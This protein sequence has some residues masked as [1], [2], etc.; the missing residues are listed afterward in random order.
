MG[1]ELARF[2]VGGGAELEEDFGLAGAAEEG[3]GDAVL[4]AVLGGEEVG[5]VGVAVLG[6]G[7]LGGADDDAV[8]LAGLDLE[9]VVEDVGGLDGAVDGATG[10]EGLDVDVFDHEAL[11]QV[12]GEGLGVG[13]L[14]EAEDGDETEL[15]REGIVG[16]EEAA[17][18]ELGVKMPASALLPAWRRLTQ[19]GPGRRP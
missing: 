17:D 11:A 19:P 16:A 5:G 6:E 14:A 3:D 7:A 13:V 4:G 10:G 8:D 9:L 1:G 2:F 15:A 18:G 12:A